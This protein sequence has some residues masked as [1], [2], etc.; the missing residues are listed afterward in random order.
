MNCAGFAYLGYTC[1]AMKQQL[2]DAINAKNLLL[3]GGQPQV[4]RVGAGDLTRDVTFT[5][6]E[7]ANL[8]AHI[9]E[10][11]AYLGACCGAPFGPRRPIRPYF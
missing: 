10:L 9:A 4:V 6:A 3:S 2:L 8:N 11:Q 7:L 5:K 1:P